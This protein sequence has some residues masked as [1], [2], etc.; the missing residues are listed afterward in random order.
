MLFIIII[1]SITTYIQFHQLLKFAD[2]TCSS[3]SY[4]V[5]MW[6]CRYR[7]MRICKQEFLCIWVTGGR[8]WHQK[9]NL[10]SK[11]SLTLR[12]ATFNITPQEPFSF[13]K[14]IWKT[15]YNG[16]NIS[17][18]FISCQVWWQNPTQTKLTR[19]P[20]YSMSSNQLEDILLSYQLT[21]EEAKKCITV[22]GLKGILSSIEL[23]LMSILNSIDRFKNHRKQSMHS[24]LQPYADWWNIADLLNN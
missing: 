13:T 16:S 15:G 4:I 9:C 10:R 1:N 12:M 21:G 20:T 18:N 7:R 23:L 11:R 19:L 14:W 5:C 17:T 2:D 8:T 22:L 24:L 6:C 3:S